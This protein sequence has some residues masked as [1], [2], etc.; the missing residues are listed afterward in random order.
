MFS[1]LIFF[2]ENLSLQRKKKFSPPPPG[3]FKSQLEFFFFFGG[4]LNA[5]Q[6]TKTLFPAPNFKA[7]KLG[8]KTH[9]KKGDLRMNHCGFVALSKTGKRNSEKKKKSK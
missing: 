3:S 4:V 7:V 2:G 5:H 8:G 1:P 6:K 9:V